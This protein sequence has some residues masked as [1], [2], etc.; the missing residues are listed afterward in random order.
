MSRHIET[1]EGLFGEKI[2]YENGEK[3]GETWEGLFPGTYN[4]YDT[5]GD[6]VGSSTIGLFADLNHYDSDGDYVGDSMRSFF[7]SMKH[8]DEDRYAGY[9][10]PMLFG[11]ETNLY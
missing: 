9:T 5:D 6:K 10:T 7:G 2:H 1:I 11:E 3:I 8:Y 4:H